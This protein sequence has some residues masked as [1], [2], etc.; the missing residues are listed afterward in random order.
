MDLT[1]FH[2]HNAND[3]T[4]DKAAW[5]IEQLYELLKESPF[6]R[7]A[8]NHAPVLKNVFR[9]DLFERAEGIVRQTRQTANPAQ[10]PEASKAQSG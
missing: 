6:N 5:L 4:D 7:P 10:E 3:P 2:R 9:R 8:G 1:I